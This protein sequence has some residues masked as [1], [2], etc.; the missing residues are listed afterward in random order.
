[1]ELTQGSETSAYQNLTPGKYPKEHTQMMVTFFLNERL[2]SL[3]WSV[4]Y[5]DAEVSTGG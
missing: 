2:K 3:S 4:K 5:F 1:M